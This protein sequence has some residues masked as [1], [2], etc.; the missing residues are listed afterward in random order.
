[1]KKVIIYII[2][3]IPILGYSQSKAIFNEM[4]FDYKGVIE[5][6][7]IESFKPRTQDGKIIEYRY[8]GGL[9]GIGSQ[10]IFFDEA[11]K[12]S[13]KYEYETHCGGDSIQ[14]DK[15]W[16]Y[17][18]SESRID[19]VIR[20]ESDTSLIRKGFRPW[21]FLYNY[22]SDSTYYETSELIFKRTSRFIQKGNIKTREYLNKDSI[23]GIV[24]KSIY[25]DKNR[26]VKFEVY[27]KGN[28]DEITILNYPDS[29][30]SKATLINH[31]KL[32]ENQVWRTENQ[33][34]KEGHI[35]KTTK[36]DPKGTY[37]THWSFLYE[38]DEKGNWI[39]KEKYNYE[40]RMLNMIKQ[41]FNYKASR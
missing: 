13:M 22:K 8:G 35:I 12:V 38:Y 3:I 16:K 24:E 26:L 40:E 41:T 1:M 2:L 33:L 32:K 31:I 28:L 27:R 4:E 5:S 29:I 10:K 14:I 39:R 6:V 25:D 19:S 21:K 17:Y 7:L 20:S 37:W 30:S 23:V 34:N 15:I 36:Y 9:F 11:G 18:Y